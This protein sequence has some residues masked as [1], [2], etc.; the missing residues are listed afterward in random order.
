MPLAPMLSSRG[1]LPVARR[2]LCLPV[3]FCTPTVCA[4]APG[5]RLPTPSSPPMAAWGGESPLT[6]CNRIA[7]AGG[8]LYA[9]TIRYHAVPRHWPQRHSS[10]H[11]HP[12][13][14]VRYR[15][16]YHFS[17]VVRPFS[18]PS[19]MDLPVS[20]GI[21]CAILL[22]SSPDGTQGAAMAT[23]FGQTT[24]PLGMYTSPRTNMG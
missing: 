13:S 9:S 15:P 5:H 17:P 10:R 22:V 23:Y 4:P 16:R 14:R 18:P 7:V 12:L 1:S 21:S 11:G 6:S 19:C 24:T 3:P 2:R 8:R 20:S